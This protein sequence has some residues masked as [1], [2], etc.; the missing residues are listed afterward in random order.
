MVDETEDT[1]Q[2]AE[3]ES[4]KCHVPAV[5]SEFLGVH[6]LVGQGK[7]VGLAFLVVQRVK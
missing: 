1:G 5:S 7:G 3:L 4:W 2:E 6:F